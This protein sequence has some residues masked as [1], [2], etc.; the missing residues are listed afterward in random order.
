MIL[1][2]FFLR[3][4][5]YMIV[6]YSTYKILHFHFLVRRTGAYRHKNALSLGP[7]LHLVNMQ[8]RS[9]HCLCAKKKKTIYT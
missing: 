5:T 8:R 6:Q 2:P 4:G 3:K 9:K 7:L 1:L